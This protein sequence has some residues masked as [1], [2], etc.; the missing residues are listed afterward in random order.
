MWYVNY[1]FK[2]AVI[3]KI[4]EKLKIIR[5]K[6]LVHIPCSGKFHTP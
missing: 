6:N 1:I 2:K 5:S 4:K 3:K